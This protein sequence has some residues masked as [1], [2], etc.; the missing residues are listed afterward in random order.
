[1]E[2]TNFV[3]WLSAIVLILSLATGVM[4]WAYRGSG[5]VAVLF[6]TPIPLP[7]VLPP[8]AAENKGIERFERGVAAFKMGQYHQA[9]DDFWQLT[10]TCPDWPEVYHN[11]G[12]L[13][14]N[15]RQDNEASHYLFQAAAY[16]GEEDRPDAIAQVKNHL[17]TI[18]TRQTQEK[19]ESHGQT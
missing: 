18:Q 19:E 7:P 6:D 2:V 11:L 17:K 3:I 10:Y 15:L 14:A 8:Q 13:S 5:S 1:M 12:L 4:I 9:K 16:Y